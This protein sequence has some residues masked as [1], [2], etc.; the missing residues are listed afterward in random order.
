M[1]AA[2]ASFGGQAALRSSINARNSVLHY[3][4][5]GLR[6]IAQSQVDHEDNKLPSLVSSFKCQGICE[7]P[8]EIGRI[9]GASVQETP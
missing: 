3:G 5:L 9:R 8:I 2:E 4:N 6:R 1:R 7:S